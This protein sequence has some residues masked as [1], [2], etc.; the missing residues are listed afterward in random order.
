[1]LHERA[2]SHGKHDLGS[3]LGKWPASAAFSSR[4][5]NCLQIYHSQDI[6]NGYMEHSLLLIFSV[7]N[8]QK[9]LIDHNE[10][11]QLF[12]GADNKQ[13]ARQKKR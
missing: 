1:M 5:Y 3:G 12:I 2:V 8:S 9:V 4:Q 6:S 13:Q 11:A 7:S 10:K